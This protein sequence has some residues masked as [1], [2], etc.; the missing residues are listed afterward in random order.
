MDFVT[1]RRNMVEGQVRTADVTDP[2]IVAAML[3]IPRERFLP[4]AKAGLAYLDFE[5]GLDQVADR[6][7][8]RLVRPMVLARLLQEAE[9][10]PRDRVLDVGCA[11]GYSAAVLSRIAGSVFALEEDA[12]LARVAER[13]LKEFGVSNVTVVTGPLAAGWPAVAPYDVILLD[14]ASQAAPR[15][16]FGQ[17]KEGGRLVGM[18]GR[19]P[20][21]GTIYRMDRGDVSG[22]P[23][24]DAAAPLLP[25]FTL[26]PAF[27][28]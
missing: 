16:L 24:F 20:A 22:R 9:I 21:R 28:F 26:T 5:V 23:I 1:A 13:T 11:T 6:P 14:G 12:A 17:L 8:R 3:D 4:P 2:N 25:G 7:G 19:A 27:V 15:T 18:I 10:A